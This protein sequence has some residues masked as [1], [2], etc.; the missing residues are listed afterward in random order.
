MK[1]RLEPTG[2]AVGIM[3]EAAFDLGKGRLEPGDTLLLHTDGVTDARDAAGK[4]FSAA[5]FLSILQEGTASAGA[6]VDRLVSALRSHM[7]GADQFDDITLLAVHRTQE[8]AQNP[9]GVSKSPG[10]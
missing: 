9:S 10:D 2:P 3:P 4:S 6:L 1:T 8:S 5:R 7:G